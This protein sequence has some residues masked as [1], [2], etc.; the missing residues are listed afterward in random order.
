MHSQQDFASKLFACGLE[1]K[2]VFIMY[3]SVFNHV[4]FVELPLVV[5]GQFIGSTNIRSKVT[6]L[7]VLFLSLNF[8]DNIPRVCD[9]S[10]KFGIHK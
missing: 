6:S 1:P 9:F 3:I 8:K 2:V 10:L 7:W 4:T 5:E